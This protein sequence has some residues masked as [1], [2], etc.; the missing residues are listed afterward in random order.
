MNQ[1]ELIEAMLN[2]A[3]STETFTQQDLCWIELILKRQDGQA[4]D[5]QLKPFIVKRHVPPK[6]RRNGMSLKIKV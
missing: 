1:K 5:M 4:G 3:K 2:S 6:I